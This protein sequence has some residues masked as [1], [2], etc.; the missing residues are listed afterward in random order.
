MLVCFF[1][2]GSSFDSEF[3]TKKVES[4]YWRT[5]REH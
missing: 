1:G 5:L 2:V 4:C 3:A